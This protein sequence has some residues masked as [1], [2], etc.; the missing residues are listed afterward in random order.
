[1]LLETVWKRTRNFKCQERP[2]FPRPLFPV[3]GADAES[4]LVPSLIKT[5]CHPTWTI[6]MNQGRGS[7]PLKTIWNILSIPLGVLGFLG[8]SDSLVTFQRDLQNIIDSYQAIVYPPFAFIFSWLWF[9]MPTPVFD[10]LFLGILFVSNELKVHGLP[11]PPKEVIKRPIGFMLM[12][13]VLSFLFWPLFA[14]EM[15]WQI[16]RTRPDGL[17]KNLAEGQKPFYVRYNL[18]DQDLLVFRYIGSVVL[19]FIIVLILNYTFLIRT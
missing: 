17:I 16:F 18:R 1:M 15:A 5:L 14:G 10:Y 9:D 2:L 4:S 11:I 8:I 3:G 13:I 7:N 12:G 19:L 6:S